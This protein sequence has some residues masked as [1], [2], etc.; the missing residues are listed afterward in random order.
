MN[1]VVTSFTTST[2]SERYATQDELR[3]FWVCLFSQTGS[4]IV[5]LSKE[6]GFEPDLI[7]TN[8]F[9]KETW[10]PGLSDMA[11][12]TAKH[13]TICTI[14][15][16]LANYDDESTVVTLH[17]YLRILPPSTAM[18]QEIYNGHPGDIVKWPQ[19]KGKD[20]QAKAIAMKLD[21][22]GCVIHRVT[23]EVDEGN[24]VRH[25][26]IKI[27]EDDTEESLILKLKELSITLWVNFLRNRLIVC[28]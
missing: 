2:V 9:K 15:E 1:N 28:A 20:P 17:G 7:L 16:N 14:V 6:L 22:T 26:A 5:R 21:S 19:L 4:E 25:L 27:S 10:H 24:I 8:N 23:P 12:S 3:P 18:S 11:V 13:D